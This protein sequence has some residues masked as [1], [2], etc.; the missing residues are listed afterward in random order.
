MTVTLL[1]LH[2]IFAFLLLGALTHQAVTSVWPRKPT[3]KGFIA[4][5]RG[6]HGHNYTNAVIVLFIITFILGGY[7][8]IFY[9]I[10]VRPPLEALLDLVPIGVFEI[11]EHFT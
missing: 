9:R 4:V 10:Q 1:I 8:Y 7:V 5:Y 2:G 6:V 3:D 11:K